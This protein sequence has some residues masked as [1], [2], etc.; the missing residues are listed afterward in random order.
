[1]PPGPEHL[2]PSDQRGPEWTAAR[3][4]NTPAARLLSEWI[5]LVSDLEY[6]LRRAQL[7][8]DVANS[9]SPTG[10][11]TETRV[12]LFRDAVISLVSCFDQQL[13]AHLDP[14]IVYKPVSGGLEYFSWLKDLRNTWVAHRGGPNRQCVVAVLVDEKTGAFQGFGHLSH[15]YMGPKA[16]DADHLIRMMELALDHARGELNKHEAAVRDEVV[17]LK[18]HERLRLPVADTTIPDSKA[19]H[20][21]RRK[22]QNIKRTPKPRSRP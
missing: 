11:D 1:M 16:D 7:W 18:N 3:T 14:S 12:S 10:R 17:E 21:G 2:N 8:R 6:A 15:L 20:M 9:E 5:L 22:F 4:L 19:I 13:A